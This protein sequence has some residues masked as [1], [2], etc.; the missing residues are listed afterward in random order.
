MAAGTAVATGRWPGCHDSVPNRV[1]GPW[2][3]CPRRP[4]PVVTSSPA[5]PH[6]PTAW[7]QSA[8]L[9]FIRERVAQILE[10]K[11]DEVPVDRA[12]DTLGL[13]SMMAFELRE[14]I[15]QNLGL[16]ISLEIFLQNITLTDLAALL[17]EKLAFQRSDNPTVAAQSGDLADEIRWRGFH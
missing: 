17:I 3:L 5:Q 15:K 7:N 14:E 16:E 6:E 10:S 12:L 2:P 8:L 1:T 13:D 9:A 11:I 4:L